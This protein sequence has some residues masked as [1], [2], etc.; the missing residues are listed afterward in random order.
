MQTRSLVFP[1]VLLAVV[2]CVGPGALHADD[3]VPPTVVGTNPPNGATG[4]SRALPI[5]AI[6]FSEP[7][8]TSANDLA[9]DFPEASP[10]WSPDKKTLYLTRTDQSSLL[11][12][13]YTYSFTLNGMSQNFRDVAGNPLPRTDFSFT[14][15]SDTTVPAVVS[16]SPA[17]GATG[18]SRSLAQVSIT[19]SEE[20]WS[21]YSITSWDTSFPAYTVSWSQ[22]KKTAYLA[23]NDQQTPLASG[24][25]YTFILNPAGYLN[26]RDLQYCYLPQT[27]FSFT[28][29]IDPGVPTVVSTDPANGA[30]GVSRDLATVSITFSEEM[31][32]GV[33]VTSNF[34][35]VSISWSAD[36]RT[37]SLTR[38]DLQT[39]LIAENTYTF[40]LNPGGTTSFQD[41][42]G[43]PLPETRFSFMTAAPDDYE[44]IKVPAAASKGFEWPYYLCIPKA[45]SKNTILLVEPNNTGTSSDDQAVH[46]AAALS[47]VSWRA[48]FAVRLGAPLLVPTFPRPINPPAPEPGGIYT[49]ALD[50]YSLLTDAIVNG[51]SIERI[52]LQLI[53]MIRDAQ[54]RLAASGF[55]VDEKVFMMGFSAS[56]AFTSRFTMLH[57]EIIQAA[58]PGSPG[59]WPLAPVSEWWGGTPLPYPVGIADVQSLTGQPVD[60]A[61]VKRVP[62]YIYVGDQDTNDALDTR[63]FPQDE[64]DVI[65]A[66]LNCNSYP[67]LFNRWPIAEEMYESAGIYNEFVIYPGVTHTITAQMF[68]DI[69]QFFKKNRPIFAD[70]KANAADGPV[71]V[72]TYDTLSISVTLD[73]MQRGDHA[74]WWLAANTPFGLY[75]YTFSGWTSNLQPAYQGPLLQCP[76]FEVVNMPAS[77]LPAGV[78]TFFF[79][80]DTVMDGSLTMGN[81]YYDFVRVN[82]VK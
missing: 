41:T 55:R 57:P 51:G 17:N 36:K 69:L 7:M 53:A 52:D 71:T 74:D 61:G 31:N 78:Y 22:D 39:R 27:T 48:D 67:Y 80:V 73:N 50:R 37:V 60:L 76:S 10:S 14:V 45:L 64:K 79:G 8:N 29:A 72:S 44:L 12:Q 11:E 54:E 30:T 19:F 56:G 5:V 25:T 82:V 23:R 24:G 62:Q 59:G 70:I 3:T 6:I 18:V 16:T 15:G 1:L 47:L 4:V 43:N 42:Q 34:P 21:G 35:P 63:G 2:F 33:S 68:E 9:S 65:C 38:T 20:M 58:A 46:D 49:Q 26:F 81:A 77:V 40:T 32:G 66:N 13:G 28:T 75:F